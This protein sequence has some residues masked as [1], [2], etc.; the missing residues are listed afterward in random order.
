M[1][2]WMITTRLIS[3]TNTC[4]EST[5]RGCSQAAGLLKVSKNIPEQFVQL[6]SVQ[7]GIV[8]TASPLYSSSIGAV[9]TTTTAST[10]DSKLDSC[11]ILNKGKTTQNQSKKSLKTF[12]NPS[13]CSI[14]KSSGGVCHF[15][16]QTHEEFCP[17]SI[18]F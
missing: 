4:I 6:G 18:K 16:A 7:T 13:I 11:P 10:C 1:I 9:L 3:I 5:Q 17:F 2:P 8:Y 12:S 14:K 15:S